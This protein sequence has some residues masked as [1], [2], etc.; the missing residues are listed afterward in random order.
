M[1]L[2][3][4]AQ[5]VANLESGLDNST[6]GHPGNA[7][8]SQQVENDDIN[9]YSSGPFILVPGCLVT[10]PTPELI[11]MKGFQTAQERKAIKNRIVFSKREACCCCIQ[12]SPLHQGTLHPIM[13]VLDFCSMYCLAV[14]DSV[15]VIDSVHVYLHK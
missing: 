11:R 2:P 3:N 5:V 9:T 7:A 12:Q 4:A 8:D 15:D 1:T 14:T 13:T 6:G 10:S